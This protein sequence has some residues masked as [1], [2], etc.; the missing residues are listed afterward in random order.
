MN[1]ISSVAVSPRIPTEADLIHAHHVRYH[2][3]MLRSFLR[4]SGYAN[5]YRDDQLPPWIDISITNADRSRAEVTEFLA[6]PLQHGHGYGAYLAKRGAQDA[7]I[8]WAG[9]LLAVVIQIGPKGFRAHGIDG[10]LYH[11]RHNGP[12]MYCTMRLSKHQG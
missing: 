6:S 7:I 10:R 3:A 2:D 11:G 9:D 5:S 4:R 1:A 12:G 8:T